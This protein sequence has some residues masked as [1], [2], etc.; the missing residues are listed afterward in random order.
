MSKTPKKFTSKPLRYNERPSH[1][2]V[3]APGDKRSFDAR[4]K[5]SNINRWD[6]TARPTHHIDSA[7]AD[8]FDAADG[9]S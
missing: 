8:P 3:T 7:P 1:A 5:P 9:E 4:P 6:G 2:P